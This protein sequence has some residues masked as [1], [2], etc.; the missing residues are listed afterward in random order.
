MS[1]F[2]R[3]RAATPPENLRTKFKRPDEIARRKAKLELRVVEGGGR[4]LWRYR[5]AKITARS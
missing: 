2:R 4:N 5:D 3:R 1:A